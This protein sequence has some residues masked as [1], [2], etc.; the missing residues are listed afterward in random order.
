[1]TAILRNKLFDHY[2]DARRQRQGLGAQQPLEPGEETTDSPEGPR[3]WPADPARALENREFWKIFDRCR[4]ELPAHLADAFVLR[5]LEQLSTEE[6]CKILD[7]SSTNLF[8]R[9]HRARM[10]LRKCLER[11]WFAPD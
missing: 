5:E 9:V 6:I 2:R 7:I 10:L 4:S 1:L 3:R 11:R 8:V